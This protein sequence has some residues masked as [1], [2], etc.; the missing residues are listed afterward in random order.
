M[1]TRKVTARKV[2]LTLGVA[3]EKAWVDTVIGALSGSIAKSMRCLG[4]VDEYD[5]GAE[6]Y[7]T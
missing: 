3:V 2:W 5:S 1:I 4:H 7:S 6:H